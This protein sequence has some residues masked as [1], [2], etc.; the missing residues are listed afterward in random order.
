MT[1]DK[2]KQKKQPKDKSEEKNKLFEEGKKAERAE[3]QREQLDEFTPPKTARSAPPPEFFKARDKFREILDEEVKPRAS[4]FS[5]ITLFTKELLK[6]GDYSIRFIEELDEIEPTLLVSINLPRGILPGDPE[7]FALH[8]LAQRITEKTRINL[9]VTTTGVGAGGRRIDYSPGK[10][11]RAVGKNLLADMPNFYACEK[12][13]RLAIAELETDENYHH[14]SDLLDNLKVLTQIYFHLGLKQQALMAVEQIERVISKLLEYVEAD[15]LN[16][17]FVYPEF[18]E[19]ATLCAII[20]E[21][22]RAF[23]LIDKNFKHLADFV[24]KHNVAMRREDPADHEAHRLFSQLP[25]D[26]T[27]SRQEVREKVLFHKEKKDF[28]ISMCA[29][30]LHSALASIETNQSE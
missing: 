15:G 18:N 17:S 29:S 27:F 4:D 25:Q 10:V 30:T 13:L 14:V 7:V 16:Y 20:G 6:H 8:E 26:L 5:V 21:Y 11:A 2:S 23:E 9:I 22:D 24:E 19:A 3:K 12:Q 28:I 1:E